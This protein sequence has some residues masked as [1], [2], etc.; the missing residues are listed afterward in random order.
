MLKQKEI[1]IDCKKKKLYKKLI[2]ARKAKNSSWWVKFITNCHDYCDYIVYIRACR[3]S[4]PSWSSTWMNRTRSSCSRTSWTGPRSR[5]S[6]T[7]TNRWWALSRLVDFGKWPQKIVIYN[8]NRIFQLYTLWNTVS[9]LLICYN[10][11][12][13]LN[14][15]ILTKPK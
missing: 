15:I 12:I 5:H 10:I 14:T 9:I 4:P 11:I 8:L 1:I 2:I 13:L 3:L 7:W 6:S